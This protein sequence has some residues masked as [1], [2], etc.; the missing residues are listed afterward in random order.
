MNDS[1]AGLV[2]LGELQ[3]VLGHGETIVHADLLNHQGFFAELDGAVS[4]AYQYFKESARIYNTLGDC[5]GSAVV[6]VLQGNLLLSESR[7]DEARRRFEEALTRLD[8]EPTRIKYRIDA[9]LG[10][11][12]CDIERGALDEAV[13]KLS[14]VSASAEA[15]SYIAGLARTHLYL[16]LAADRSGDREL[17]VQQA[18]RASRY[19]QTTDHRVL[20]AAEVLMYSLTRSK[21]AR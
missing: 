1:S 2:T 4:E 20:I 3:A 18:R 7:Y 12:L 19:A 10:M 13:G 21:E 14:A 15:F 17:A 11:A 9:E 16:A 5:Q 6:S 8:Q